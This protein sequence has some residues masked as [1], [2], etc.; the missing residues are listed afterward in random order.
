M[1]RTSRVARSRARR[2]ERGRRGRASKAWGGAAGGLKSEADQTSQPFRAGQIGLRVTLRLHLGAC[3]GFGVASSFETARPEPAAASDFTM[4]T[5]LRPWSAFA[6]ER[7]TA[8]SHEAA[9]GRRTWEVWRLVASGA[10]SWQVRGIFLWVVLGRDGRSSAFGRQ[11]LHLSE[12]PGRGKRLD[13]HQSRRAGCL[14]RRAWRGAGPMAGSRVGRPWYDVR[15]PGH[16]GADGLA[17]RR[18]AAPAGRRDH[19]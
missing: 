15:G 4:L 16:R 3:A 8:V 1:E 10:L 2:R 19:G 17:V 14:L 18:G 11:R 9:P 7:G 12:R 5:L 13:R 6:S